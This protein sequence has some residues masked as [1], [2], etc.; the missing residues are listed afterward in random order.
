MMAWSSAMRS[1]N[2]VWY[3]Q[4]GVVGIIWRSG[5]AALAHPSLT[6]GMRLEQLAQRVAALA[7]GSDLASMVVCTSYGLPPGTLVRNCWRSAAGFVSMALRG[8]HVAAFPE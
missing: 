6:G 8:H 7:H 4:I 2:S 1:R 3:A 5:G